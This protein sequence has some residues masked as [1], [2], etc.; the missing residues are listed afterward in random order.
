[1]VK[2]NKLLKKDSNHFNLRQ[3]IWLGFNYTVGIA[4]IGNLAILS[5]S[6]SAKNSDGLNPDGISLHVL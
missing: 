2:T 4:F 5:N 6:S 1:M 3:F